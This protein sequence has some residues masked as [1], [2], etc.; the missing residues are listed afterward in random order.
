MRLF[1]SQ[2]MENLLENMLNGV[3]FCKMIYENDQPVD[4]LFLF[5][6]PAFHKQTGLDHVV[7]HLVSEII[8]TIRESD[9]QLFEIYGRVA[10]DG[11]PEAF[12]MFVEG[13]KQWLSVS[14]YCPQPGH[15][16]TL[17]DDITERKNAEKTLHE[18][19]RQLQFV[20]EGS[21]LG[22]WDWNIATNKVIRNERWAV[23]LG[24]SHA[25]MQQT[26]KQWT[27]FVHPDDR[28][29]AWASINNVLE[30]RTTSHKLE[31]R[32][33]HKDGSIRWILDQAKVMERDEHGRAVRMCG[34]H[35]D[36][37]DRKALEE[38][39]TRQAHIDYLTGINNRRYFM[40][41]AE[42]ELRRANRSGNQ[43][44][45]FMLD[46]DHFKRINDRYG[47]KVGDLVLKML[48]QV[49]QSALRDIDI[50]ARMGGE[51]FAVLLPET[52]SSLAIEVAR[53]LQDSINKAS[54]P[55][56]GD[57][58]IKIQVS[59]GVASMTSPY[60]NMD[61]LLHRA[62]TALYEAKNTG[63]NRICVAPC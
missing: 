17:F 7:G 15:F 42:H 11:A 62:D 55:L 53:R 26:T 23:M 33:L 46:I 10:R 47:H 35:T 8:P 5:T 19:A 57:L 56:E 40:E 59:I 25:E 54:L 22:F 39:L 34:T 20:L 60:D 31:Y 9:P 13:L 32:M 6:N 30:G 24:Y 52:E 2:V 3:A 44:S 36:V 28:D 41:R 12:V 29:F 49:C 16:I 37:T 63:R 45:I 4:F 48:A 50:L 14:V 18:R 43:L 38:E 27:D 21:E 61:I 1:S 58:V 51:E